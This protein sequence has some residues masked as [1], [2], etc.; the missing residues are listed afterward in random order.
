M[1]QT[2]SPHKNFRY[3]FCF[4]VETTNFLLKLTPTLVLRKNSNWQAYPEATKIHVD[5]N[6]IISPVTALEQRKTNH[7][8]I[9]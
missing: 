3:N 4:F 8:T 7:V 9:T 2:V 6:A 1:L 5:R